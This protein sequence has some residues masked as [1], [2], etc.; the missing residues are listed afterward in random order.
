MLKSC[1]NKFDVESSPKQGK[2][3]TISG[4]KNIIFINVVED[5]EENEDEENVPEETNKEPIN[6]VKKTKFDG[7]NGMETTKEGEL[8]RTDVKKNKR[9]RI[10]EKK[11]QSRNKKKNSKKS[12]SEM[13]EPMPLITMMGIVLVSSAFPII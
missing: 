5:I 8:K 7:R 3:V 2:K 6:G 1:Q 9:T 11:R 13:K 12:L 10:G 4:L